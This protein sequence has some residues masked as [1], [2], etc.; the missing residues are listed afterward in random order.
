MTIWTNLSPSTK[1][2]TRDPAQAPKA[3][4]D[5]LPY[6]RQAFG[7]LPGQAPIVSG[8]VAPSAPDVPQ[9]TVLGLYP[10]PFSTVTIGH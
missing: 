4:Y 1:P 10:S 6:F 3:N 7:V 8:V 5:P 2:F 9:K